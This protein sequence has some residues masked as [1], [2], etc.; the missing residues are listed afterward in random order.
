MEENI[1]DFLKEIENL[2]SID[3]FKA[4]KEKQKE[5]RN[6]T[7]EKYSTMFHDFNYK[8]E[9]TILK[10]NRD[11]T[12]LIEEIKD[13]DRLMYNK[14]E[15]YKSSYRRYVEDIVQML[16]KEMP[17]YTQFFNQKNILEIYSDNL[18][19]PWRM[20]RIEQYISDFDE[21]INAYIENDTTP[22]YDKLKE[23]SKDCKVFKFVLITISSMAGIYVLEN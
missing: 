8:L 4:I 16:N 11:S 7:K 9:E 2:S 5:V 17:C 19:E 14:R 18:V 13:F 23:L 22:F 15:V 10:I 3:R 12:T 21:Y 20:S 1:Q 6:L